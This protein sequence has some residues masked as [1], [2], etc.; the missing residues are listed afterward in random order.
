MRIVVVVVVVSGLVLV[1]I[2]F[3]VVVFGE[4]V[5]IGLI[6]EGVKVKLIVV[7][8]GNVIKFKVG[9]MKVKCNE[10]GMFSND[11]GSYIGFDILDSGLFV[12]KCLTVSN[13]GGYYFK[14]NLMFFGV[15]VFD[16]YLGVGVIVGLLLIIVGLWLLIDG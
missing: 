2:G 12:D 14:M 15:V 1:V 6:V 16:E 10:G 11:V 8:V 3:V 4:I 13:F 5:Y 7:T 9:K